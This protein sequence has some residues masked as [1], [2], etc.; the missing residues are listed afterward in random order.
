MKRNSVCVEAARH[1]CMSNRRRI[2]YHLSG[3]AN[4]GHG[5]FGAE[6]S[7]FRVGICG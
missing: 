1:D 6:A 7:D 2:F 3:S 5:W 4:D